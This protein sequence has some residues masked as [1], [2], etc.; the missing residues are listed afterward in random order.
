[1]EQ[2]VSPSTPST[3]STQGHPGRMLLAEGCLRLP[4]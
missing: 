4:G 1:M 3:P 2:R